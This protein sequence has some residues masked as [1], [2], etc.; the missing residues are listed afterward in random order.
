MGY[1]LSIRPFKKSPR[2]S[3][4]LSLLIWLDFR[5]KNKI[6]LQ[7]NPLRTTPSEPFRS[8]FDSRW[9]RADERRWNVDC[10]RL[11]RMGGHCLFP[12]ATVKLAPLWFFCAEASTYFSMATSSRNGGDSG[13]FLRAPF[14]WEKNGEPVWLYV[15]KLF[16]LSLCYEWRGLP[17]LFFRIAF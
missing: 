3:V 8:A 12:V 5:C 7:V 9:R 13:M 16:D 6:P 11:T 1:K 14:A 10:D 4:T 2:V 15:V 17:E